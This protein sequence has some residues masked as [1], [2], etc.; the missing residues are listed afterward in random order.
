MQQNAALAL[1]R[2]P[3]IGEVTSWHLAKNIGADVSKP[4]RHLVRV[5][6]RF[7]YADVSSMCKDIS[8][9]VGDKMSVA[10]LVLWRFEERTFAY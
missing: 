2:L 6:A 4:D 7:G 5:A 1:Q 10:D 3:Y 9:A 8:S